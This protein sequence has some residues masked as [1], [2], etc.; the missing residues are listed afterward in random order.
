M[1]SVNILF[2]QQAKW[3]QIPFMCKVCVADKADSDQIFFRLCFVSNQATNVWFQQQHL[4]M[5]PS[6]NT[7]LSQYMKP[8]IHIYGWASSKSHSKTQFTLQHM[9][10]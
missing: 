9:N 2:V 10:T 7:N 6:T 8:Y 4:N 5:F 3:H 1:Y